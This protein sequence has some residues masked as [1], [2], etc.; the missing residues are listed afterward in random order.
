M[1]YSAFYNKAKIY[2][3]LDMPQEMMAEAE[4]LIK[5]GYDESDGKQLL[6]TARQLVE[7]F[8]KTGLD[9][10]HVPFNN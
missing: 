1:R 7:E 6:E 10:R 5:N 9:T 8:K 3:Y 2:Y 4:G